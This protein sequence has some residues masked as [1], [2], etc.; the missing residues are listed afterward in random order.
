MKRGWLGLGL[1]ALVGGC[2][3]PASWQASNPPAATAEPAPAPYQCLVAGEARMLVAELFF[4]RDRAGQQTVSDAE[5]ADFLASVVT[6]NFPDG[7][8]V[9]DGYGQWRNPT[10]GAIGRS[11]HASA[12]TCSMAASRAYSH[13]RKFI[14]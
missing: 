9:F 1:A 3:A 4:G 6:P 8:T 12:W 5:W 14:H 11:P 13:G 7:L 10:T 2:A